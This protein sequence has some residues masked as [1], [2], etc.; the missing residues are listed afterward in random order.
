MQIC[1]V[2]DRSSS[3]RWR[4]IS[5][6]EREISSSYRAIVFPNTRKISSAAAVSRWLISSRSISI[7]DMLTGKY[8]V[9]S[10]TGEKHNYALCACVV[11]LFFLWDEDPSMYNIARLAIAFALF[12]MAAR[13]R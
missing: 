2:L 7:F 3:R 8:G 9:C 6:L 4:S 11:S 13:N 5:C 1:G 12:K 10:F